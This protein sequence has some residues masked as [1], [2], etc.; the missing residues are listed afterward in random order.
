MKKSIIAAAIILSTG[1]VSARAFMHRDTTLT[2][3]SLPQKEESTPVATNADQVTKM[4]KKD[5]GTAD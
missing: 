5:I 4:T 1:I 2:T 3:P